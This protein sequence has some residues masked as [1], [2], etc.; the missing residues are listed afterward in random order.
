MAVVSAARPA[1]SPVAP[2]SETER[3]YTLDAFR[4]FTMVW[5]FSQAFGL[6]YFR[7]HPAMGGLARQFTHHDWHGM[8]AWD[9]IQ[10]FFMFIVGAAM[11]FAFERRWSAGEPWGLSLWHVLRRSALLILLGTM[12]RSIGAGKP[13]LDLI[14]VLAQ[15]AFTYVVAFLVLRRSW[16][17]QAAT[18]G[19]FLLAHWAIYVFLIPSGAAGAWEKGTNIGAWLDGLVLGKNWG[20]GYAT[21]N[22]I[23]ETANT[24]FGVM[25]GSLLMSSQP[26]ARKMRILALTGVAALALGLALDPLVPSIKRIWTASFAIYSTGYTLLALVVF[27]W[28]CD[29]RRW[30]GWAKVFVIVGMNSIFIYLFHEILHRWLNQTARVFL[31][32]AVTWWGPWGQMLN[33]WAVVGFEIYVCWWLWRRRIFFKL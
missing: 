14:N 24:I 26:A 2:A 19:A 16:R 18:A 9:L 33:V 31:G 30:R 8:Y 7:D 10:P 21:I 28:L 22:C 17:V 15:I 25:A 5:M 23:S 32:W 1:A 20:G 12:A 13:I 29:V 6:L 3:L 27:Y 11:P 4:G